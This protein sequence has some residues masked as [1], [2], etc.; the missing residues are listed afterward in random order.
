VNLSKN[1]SRKATCVTTKFRKPTY[2]KAKRNW[3][4]G[5]AFFPNTLSF[6]FE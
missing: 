5:F 3:W 6:H 1:G 4:T 2:G